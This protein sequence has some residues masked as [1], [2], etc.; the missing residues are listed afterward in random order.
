MTDWEA[1]INLIGV[2]RKPGKGYQLGPYQPGTIWKLQLKKLE[3]IFV[4]SFL[5]C[6]EFNYLESNLGFRTLG[7]DILPP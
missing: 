7:A 1:A 4:V 2:V 3:P 6:Q 5:S